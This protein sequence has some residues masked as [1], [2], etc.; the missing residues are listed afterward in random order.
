LDLP[1]AGGAPVAGAGESADVED[2][3]QLKVRDGG[4]ELI[5]RDL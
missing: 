1:V 5:F 4:H 2:R 3:S